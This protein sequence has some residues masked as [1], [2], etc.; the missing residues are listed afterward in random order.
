MQNSPLEFYKG[1]VAEYSDKTDSLKRTHRIIVLLRLSVFILAVFLP[2]AFISRSALIAF[3][4]FAPLIIIFFYLVRKFT[5][6]EKKIKYF[7]FLLD[8]NLHEIEALNGNFTNFK[9]G[10]RIYKS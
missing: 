10:D 7:S 1:K 9:D 4:I 3:L 5:I 8:I 6:I 2:L